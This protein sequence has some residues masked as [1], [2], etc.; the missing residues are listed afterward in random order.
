MALISVGTSIITFAIAVLHIFVVADAYSQKGISDNSV[1]VGQYDPSTLELDEL[2]FYD[3]THW[4]SYRRHWDA[5]LHD[6]MPEMSNNLRA[7]IGDVAYNK[8]WFPRIDEWPSY[9]VVLD[10]YKIPQEISHDGKR[11]VFYRGI[12]ISWD[13]LYDHGGTQEVNYLKNNLSTTNPPRSSVRNVFNED[14]NAALPAWAAWVIGSVVVPSIIAWV[15]PELKEAFKKYTNDQLDPQDC[16]DSFEKE[17][18]KQNLRRSEPYSSNYLFWLDLLNSAIDCEAMK[19]YKG[20]GHPALPFKDGAGP[21]GLTLQNIRLQ[22]NIEV[23]GVDDEFF[24]ADERVHR[25]KQVHNNNVFGR[26]R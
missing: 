5:V 4:E 8:T 1:N 16:P 19:N 2:P 13:D 9:V 11:G 10:N 12:F 25:V 18:Y 24:G 3:T 22:G 14:P 17:R 6:Y 26:A 21:R 7:H 20:K 23:E 15:V